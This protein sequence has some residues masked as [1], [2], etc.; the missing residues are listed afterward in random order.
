MLEKWLKDRKGR[1]LDFDD[2]EHYRRIALALAATRRL[3]IEVDAPA[4]PLFAA[5]LAETV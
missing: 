2:V 1:V 4:A 5:S 3:M